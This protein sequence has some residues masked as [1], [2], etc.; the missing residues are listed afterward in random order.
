VVSVVQERYLPHY[1][2][3]SRT[4][5]ATIEVIIEAPG[6]NNSLAGGLNCPNSDKADYVTPVAA[7][8]EEYLKDGMSLRWIL[9]TND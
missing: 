2:D 6:F 3:S 5:N 8:Y 1:S 4:N 9:Q 7:W